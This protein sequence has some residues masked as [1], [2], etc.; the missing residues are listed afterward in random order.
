MNVAKFLRTAFLQNTSRSSRLQ[1]F[2]KIGI[3]KNFA[4]VTGK[5]LRWS[6]FSINL[7]AEGLQLHKKRLQH[8]CFPVKFAKFLRATF[9]IEH[10]QW[11]L[12]HLRWLLLYFFYDVLIIFSSLYIVWCI[13]SRTRLFINLS[14]IVRFLNNSVRVYPIKLKIGILDHMNNTVRNTVF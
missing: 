14:S 8:R 4:N 9:H 1:I 11:L 2:L 3:L 12:L 13:K 6:L 10:L 7:Q 5:E